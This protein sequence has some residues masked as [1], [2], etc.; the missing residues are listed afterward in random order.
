[1]KELKYLTLWKDGRWVFM[2]REDF[3]KRR[4]IIWRIIRGLKQLV[5]R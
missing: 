2:K 5:R 4:G 3:F 1:M